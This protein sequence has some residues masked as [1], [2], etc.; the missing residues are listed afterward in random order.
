MLPEQVV[1]A[2]D[3]FQHAVAV[4]IRA[5]VIVRAAGVLDKMLQNATWPALF[6]TGVVAL[7]APNT[8]NN[9]PPS[10]AGSV[11]MAILVMAASAGLTIKNAMSSATTSAID[12][13]PTPF[14]LWNSCRSGCVILVNCQ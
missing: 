6:S 13:S 14:V 4:K 9:P 2:D 7:L 1:L 5:D 3:F 12:N 10:G 8:P 11:E